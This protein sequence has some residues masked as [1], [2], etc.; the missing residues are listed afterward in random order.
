M[1]RA[2]RSLSLA[3]GL[4]AAAVVAGLPAGASISSA[5]RSLLGIDDRLTD[6]SAVALTFDD[7]PHPQGTPAVLDVLDRYRVKATF[8]LVGEQVDLRPALAAEIVERGHEIGIHS[9][10]HRAATWRAPRAFSDDLDRAADAIARATGLAPSLYRPPRGVFTYSALAE[11]RRRGWFPVLWAADGRDWRRTATPA[12]ISGRIA[13]RLAG[14][15]VVLLHDSDFYSS[16]GSWKN[17]LDALPLLLAA[18][19]GKRLSPVLLSR[20]SFP[21]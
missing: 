15:E 4:T 19:E 12:R 20:Q 5:S 16:P 10:R 21:R 1:T 2:G 18:M 9:Y 7:G 13:R 11:V 3:L 14:G 17:T 6:L 8:F